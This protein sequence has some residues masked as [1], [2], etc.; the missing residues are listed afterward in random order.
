MHINQ[1][2]RLKLD[3]K[4]KHEKNINMNIIYQGLFESNKKD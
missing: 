2:N 3:L 4:Y 1:N